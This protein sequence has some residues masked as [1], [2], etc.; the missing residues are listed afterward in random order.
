MIFSLTLRFVIKIEWFSLFLMNFWMNNYICAHVNMCVCSQLQV[1]LSI[2]IPFSCHSNLFHFIIFH[3][4]VKVNYAY[5][6]WVQFNVGACVYINVCVFCSTVG[7]AGCWCTSL[8]STFIVYA[9]SLKCTEFGKKKL[10]Y[11]NTTKAQR[12][13]KIFSID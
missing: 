5:W 9:K 7:C 1:Q 11:N 2:I 3:F 13:A 10:L 12:C 6:W 8:L 4:S